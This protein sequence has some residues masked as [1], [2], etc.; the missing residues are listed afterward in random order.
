M[1]LQ[2]YNTIDEAFKGAEKDDTPFVVATEGEL[3]VVGDANKTQLNIHDFEITFRTPPEERGGAYNYLTKKYEGVYIT[4]RKETKVL[5][6]ITSMMPFFKDVTPEGEV[7][8]LSE[9]EKIGILQSVEDEAF[10]IM[11]DLVAFVLGVDEMLKEYMTPV[12]VMQSALQI[13]QGYPE[14]VNEADTFFG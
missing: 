4:P 6:L 2:E 12:S 1:T 14:A 5:K 3:A 13:I 10:D 7:R 11:Y 9:E 8:D